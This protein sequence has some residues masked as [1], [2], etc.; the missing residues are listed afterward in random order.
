M[1]PLG[2]KVMAVNISPASLIPRKSCHRHVVG[3]VRGCKDSRAT[4]YEPGS[5]VRIQF[6]GR[7]AHERSL[8]RTYEWLGG[9]VIRNA[10][11]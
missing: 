3:L 10:D 6:L 1:D 2:R 4:A 11:E 9:K 7:P 5:G 8:A